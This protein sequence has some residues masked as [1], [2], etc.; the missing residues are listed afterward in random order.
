[1]AE[2]RDQEGADHDRVGDVVHVLDQGGLVAVGAR[3]LALEPGLV[4]HVP[5]VDREAQPAARLQAGPDGV[6]GRDDRVDHRSGPRAAGK[7]GRS[8]GSGS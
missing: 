6:G 3:V 4:P 5:L 1:V 7:V 2:Q 8:V